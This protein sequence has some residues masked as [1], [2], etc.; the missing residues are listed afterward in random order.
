MQ[1][2]IVLDD[3]FAGD[4]GG[5][6]VGWFSVF[7]TGTIIESGTT[8]TLE[9]DAAIAS[10]TTIDL[11]LGAITMTVDLVATDGRAE[12]A[13]ANPANVDH[14]FLAKIRASDGELQVKGAN[15]AHGEEEAIVGYVGGYAGGPIRMTVVLDRTS[16]SLSTESPP[17][18]SGPTAYSSVFSSFSRS[19]LGTAAWVGLAND[20]GSVAAAA[21]IFDRIVVDVAEPAA[22]ERNTFSQVKVIYRR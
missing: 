14:H 19:D 10:N 21:S 20:S 22:V 16:F 7:G 4:T 1:A 2:D 15:A 11:T 18:S 13:V 17:F 3:H 6:P 8:V 5:M 12:V 9:G